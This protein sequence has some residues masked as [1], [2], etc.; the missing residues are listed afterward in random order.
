MSIK[1]MLTDLVKAQAELGKQEKHVSNLKKQFKEA[2]LTAE[3]DSFKTDDGVSCVLQKPKAR[4]SFNRKDE[5][6]AYMV[7]QF[8]DEQGI[9]NIYTETVHAGTFSSSITSLIEQG[10]EI[11][12]FIKIFTDRTLTITGRNKINV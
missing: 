1:Q 10:I 12:D 6:V 9:G 11:P 8:C 3:L 7:K 2:M 5:N 4:A